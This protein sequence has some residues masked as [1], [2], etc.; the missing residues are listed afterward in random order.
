MVFDGI[1]AVLTVVV[2]VLKDVPL[3][4]ERG[5]SGANLHLPGQVQIREEDVCMSDVCMK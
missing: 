5:S 1:L 4:L 2:G 3:V